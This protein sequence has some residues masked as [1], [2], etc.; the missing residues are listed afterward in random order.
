[1]RRQHFILPVI[2]TLA[3]ICMLSPAAPASQWE[4]AIY[5]F[6]PGTGD[7]YAPA[8]GL[9]ADAK[10]NL[11]GTTMFGGA[12]C[13]LDGCGTVYEL[14]PSN[15]GR[16]WT[17]TVLYSFQGA[18]DGAFPAG[19]LVL[20]GQG[21]L[22]G[23]TSGGGASRA[24]VI[25]QLTPP[26]EQG[27]SWTET[28]LY[29]FTAPNDGYFPVTLTMD[30]SGNL[31]GAEPGYPGGFGSVFELSPG[32]GGSWTF[33]VLYNFLGGAEHDGTRP[34]G[35]LVLSPWGSLLGVTA[36]GGSGSGC[37]ADGCG[38]VFQLVAQKN[39][40][41][42]ERVVYMFSGGSD[43]GVPVGLSMD[44]PS[45]TFYGATAYGGDSTGD[46]VVFQL[47]PQKGG[48]WTEATV[49]TF[50]QSSDLSRPN[51]AAA[52]DALGNLYGTTYLSTAG[53]GGVYKLSPPQQQGGAWTETVQYQFSGGADGGNNPSALLLSGTQQSVFGATEYGGSDEGGVV[54]KVV[55]H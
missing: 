40:S 34:I 14:S 7:G 25:F 35:A 28:V 10:G 22:Y 5:Q 12:A 54:F 51:S 41:W 20:S 33:S 55:L 19:A 39:G 50:G 52:A 15:G 23:T 8:A 30:G 53:D 29:N 37:N 44:R 6:R 17:E 4:T 9:I 1:M 26:A 18:P 27:G 21:S 24:G 43:G 31:Y 16:T 13:G 46:G 49:F 2:A 36:A 45:R 38:T 47:A 48:G 3:A 42:K 11:Y 32:G